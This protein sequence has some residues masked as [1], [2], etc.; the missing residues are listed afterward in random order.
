MAA[1]R[2]RFIHEHEQLNGVFVLRTRH[3]EGLLS[4]SALSITQWSSKAEQIRQ[5]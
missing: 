4:L 1:F 3:F 2:G 5:M